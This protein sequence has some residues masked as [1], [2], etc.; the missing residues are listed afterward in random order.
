MGLVPAMIGIA[1]SM[2]MKAIAE[3]VETSEQ[4]SQIRDLNCNFAQGN[5]FS[6]PMEPQLMLDL[7]LAAPQW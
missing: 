6:E 7:M 5:L 3:G 1:H 4:L 2:G